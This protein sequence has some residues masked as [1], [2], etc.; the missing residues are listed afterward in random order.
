MFSRRR[1]SGGVQDGWCRGGISTNRSVQKSGTT[2]LEGNSVRNDNRE[3]CNHG[4]KL[5]SLD[6]LKS[7]IMCNFVDCSPIFRPR[8]FTSWKGRS[9]HGS[10]AVG[11][12]LQERA[13]YWEFMVPTRLLPAVPR[14]NDLSVR[15]CR[16]CS[17]STPNV[18]QAFSLIASTAG[19]D[20]DS[21]NRCPET[22]V[23][24]AIN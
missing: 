7:E 13:D 23:T 8:A 1:Y 6:T 20:T 22:L 24:I 3:V 21:E 12:I 11:F 14:N 9:Q 16:I 15:K 19:T 5:V 18:I 4:K 2:C 17:S 10:P